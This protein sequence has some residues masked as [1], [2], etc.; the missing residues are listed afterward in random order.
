G[1]T[2][3]VLTFNLG[4]DI[5]AAAQD[6][7]AAIAQTLRRLPDGITPPS[8]QKVNPADD[9]ILFLALT[10]STLPLSTLS[11][12]GEELIAQRISMV[13]GVAQVQIY[14]AQ[15]FAV[16]VQVDPRRLASRQIG[17]DEVAAAIR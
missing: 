13:Q 17:I 12:Y 9:P 14:G 5:D 11:E 1:S 15:K 4:R 2:S 16:R 6:V 3:I 10:S 7:Q 8:Y